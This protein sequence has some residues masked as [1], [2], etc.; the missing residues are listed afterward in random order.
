M[1]S[2]EE[3][4][5]LVKAARLEE[6]LQQPE[7]QTNAL[8]LLQ[9]LT[10]KEIYGAKRQLDLIE[11]GFK[12]LREAN[13][14]EGSRNEAVEKHLEELRRDKE[15]FQLLISEAEATAKTTKDGLEGLRAKV[16]DEYFKLTAD[17]ARFSKD[18]KTLK[19][20][21]DH[22]Q[23]QLSTVD[24]V[25]KDFRATLP[26]PQDITKI[27]ETLA[28]VE[29]MVVSLYEKLDAVSKISLDQKEALMET[30]TDHAQIRRF[31]EAFTPRQEDFL[32]FLEKIPE[33]IS[34]ITSNDWP[35]DGMTGGNSC[36]SADPGSS[37]PQP[38]QKAVLML[39]QYNHFSNSYRIK[40]P[41]SEARFIRQYLKKI[42]HK[43]AWLMQ[44][45]L[46][47]E[48]PD[49]AVPLQQPEINRKTDVVIFLDLDKL[50]WNHI[51]IIMRQ[52]SSRELFSLLEMEEEGGYVSLSC[53][54]SRL[55]II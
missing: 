49:L 37:G 26:N 40:H 2:T 12:K 23:G 52:I 34:S 35:L 55:E 42:D 46:Q 20:Q 8:R 21:I 50:C 3:S 47:Q 32:Q 13:I 33:I 28:R 24:G 36:Q 4:G 17:N 53:N 19:K 15:S 43:A 16:S 5:K 39:E 44:M 6:R 27:N 22:H 29:S 1:H 41:K 30:I 48:Y 10:I 11:A 14:A 9:A 31:L 7:N 25:I 38:P 18:I 45:K 51:K 54:K